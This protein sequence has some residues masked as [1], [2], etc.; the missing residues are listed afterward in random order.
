[1]KIFIALLLF[2]LPMFAMNFNS[3]DKSFSRA[4]AQINFKET[5]EAA[6]DFEKLYHEFKNK[7]NIEKCL[8]DFTKT[9]CEVNY[10][11]GIFLYEKDFTDIQNYPLS[12]KIMEAGINRCKNIC[13][14]VRFKAMYG[15]LLIREKKMAQ[16]KKMFIQATAQNKNTD[17]GCWPA[18]TEEEYNFIEKEFG[19]KP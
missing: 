11:I 9:E 19:L 18:M 13:D 3:C 17:G 10:W 8:K 6:K 15:L 7:T 2:T 14:E 12:E 5:R 16:A 4:L 1:M